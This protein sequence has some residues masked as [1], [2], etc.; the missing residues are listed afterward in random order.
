MRDLVA[1]IEFAEPLVNEVQFDLLARAGARVGCRS[2]A[3][4]KSGC[5]IPYSDQRVRHF[6]KLSTSHWAYVFACSWITRSSLFVNADRS[7]SDSLLHLRRISSRMICLPPGSGAA[8][9]R[10]MV[11][12][13]FDQNTAPP[14]RPPGGGLVADYAI[15]PMTSSPAKATPDINHIRSPALN[16]KTRRSIYDMSCQRA[17]SGMVP[18]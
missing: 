12:T 15:A 5:P 14:G 1:E 18:L 16:S 2:G 13:S 17:G 10:S 11:I 9:M 6:M 8:G 4:L 3:P 7:C